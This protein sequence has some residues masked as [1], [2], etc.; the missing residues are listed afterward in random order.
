MLAAFTIFRLPFC[1]T[2]CKQYVLWWLQSGHVY[3]DLHWDN[4]ACD[5]SKTG[6]FLLDLELCDEI[7]KEPDFNMRSWGKETLV[8]GRYTVASDLHNLGRMLA[9]LHAMI[10]TEEGKSFVE[11]LV[12]PAREQQHSAEQLL[13]HAW[14]GCEGVHCG[15]AGAHPNDS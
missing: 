15:A 10:A 8:H 14:I 13:S 1:A 3:R 2:N 5:I 11:E 6:Y 12:R 7:D 9:E 4:G